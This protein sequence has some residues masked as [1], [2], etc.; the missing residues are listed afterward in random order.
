MVKGCDSRSR[1]YSVS[2]RVGTESGMSW[3]IECGFKTKKEYSRQGIAGTESR[4]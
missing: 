4:T 2:R 3:A 1:Y